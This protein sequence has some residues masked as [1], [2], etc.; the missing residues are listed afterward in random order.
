MKQRI[1]LLLLALLAGLG[2]LNAKTTTTTLWEGTYT[3]YIAIPAANLMAGGTVTVYMTVTDGTKLRIVYKKN[4]ANQDPEAFTNSGGTIADWKWQNVGTAS[5]QFSINVADMSILNDNSEGTGSTGFLYIGSEDASKLT[6]SR[7]TFSKEI[8]PSSETELLDSEWEVSWSTK[9]FAAQS[10][11]KKGDVLRFHLTHTYDGEGWD[12]SQFYIKDKDGNDIPLSGT[13]SYTISLQ[14]NLDVDFDYEITNASDLEI[15]QNSGFG[16]KGDG[17]T[18]T[19]AKLLTYSDSYD[20][21]AVTIGSD[22]IAT[23]SSSKKLDFSGTGITAYYA[24]SVAEGKV[25]LTSTETTHDWQGYILVGETGTYDVPVASKASYSSENYLR[26]CVNGS[27]VAAST[28]G[29]YHYI[30][31]KNKAGK[32]AFYKLTAAHT[33][34]AKK[35]YLETATD[36]TPPGAGVKGVSL[37]FTDEVT[38]ISTVQPA[39]QNNAIYTLSGVRVTNP[40]R[41]LYIVGGHKVFFK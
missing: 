4:N 14:K 24:S 8:T 7:I 12:Y 27:S 38:G 31:A 21:V 3:D 30:F 36:I 33:L 28:E 37:V 19:S 18:L 10:G 25:S 11:A 40:T 9:A 35:A 26:Q 5:Y 20:A 39:V 23:F 41:G 15:I 13:F 6:I 17:C 29:T 2:S 22:G 1:T 32:I 34:G 16:L